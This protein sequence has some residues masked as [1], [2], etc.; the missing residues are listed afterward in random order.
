MV[1][2]VLVA[3][4]LRCDLHGEYSKIKNMIIFKRNFILL[5]I[6]FLFSI[7]YI[8]PSFALTLPFRIIWDRNTESD[9]AYYTVHYGTSPLY[10]SH[11]IDV[12][13]AYPYCEFCDR[14]SPDCGNGKG[15][16]TPGETYYIS[17]TAFDLSLNESKDSNQLVIDINPSL[18][19]TTTGI[20]TSTTTTTP[21]ITIRAV[22]EAEEMSHHDYGAQQ[23]EFW[24]LWANGEM[25]EEVGFPDTGVYQFEIIAKGSL[26]YDVGPEMGLLIDGAIKHTVFVNTE[27]PETFSFEVQVT[28][29]THEFAIGFYNDYHEASEGIDRNL[30]VDKTTIVLFP[31]PDVTSTTTTST[32]VIQKK[33]CSLDPTLILHGAIPEE[34]T[35]N[36]PIDDLDNVISASLLITLFD[37]DISGEG[38]IYINDNTSR[39]IP[40]GPY[41]NMEHSFEVPINIGWLSQGGNIF[42]FTHVASWGYEVRELCVKVLVKELPD[43]TTTIYIPPPPTS[44][45]TS[46]EPDETPPTGRVIINKGN[47]TANSRIV[48]LQISAEDDESGM[49]VGAQMM[50]SNDNIKWFEPKPI[51]APKYWVLSEGEGEKTVYVKFCDAAGNWMSQPVSDS[52]RLEKNTACIKPIQLTA[53]AL[54]CSDSF[55]PLWS[56]EKTVDGETDTGWLSP[57][58]LFVQEEYVTLDLGETKIVSRVEICSNPFQSLDLF[59]QDFQI[60]VSTDNETW[61]EVLTVEHYSPPASCTDSWEFDETKARYV[62]MVTTKPKP[63]LFFFHL[64]Y[65]AEIKVHGC[66]ETEISSSQ[67]TFA[68]TSDRTETGAIELTPGLQTSD[69]EEIKPSETPPGRPG[70]PGFILK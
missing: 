22:I 37:A 59:P 70:K 29:G 28:E 64:T 56:K 41:D 46:L 54:D 32:P 34:G 35:M 50:Q 43:T 12:D 60:Q 68:I 8:Q 67:S 44:T 11:G 57:L 5:F 21:A 23:G 13:K 20:N 39:E 55:L 38:Y 58:R 2:L 6:S 62:K 65:I 36:V 4:M 26:A 45:T 17:I 53:T 3:A 61:T 51:A 48:N 18:T 25:S 52:I 47:E 33:Y 63:F 19:T 49:G 42:R 16:L 31:V 66:S 27:T 24:N 1:I 9:L 10:Y 15:Q 14:E 30:Y 69:K 7:G 40:V